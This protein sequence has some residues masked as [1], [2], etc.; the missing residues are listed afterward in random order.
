MANLMVW[1][2]ALGVI[3][4]AAFMEAQESDSPSPLY[5]EEVTASDPGRAEQ[6][7]ELQKYLAGWQKERPALRKRFTPD[8]ASPQAYEVSTRK[9]RRT[10]RNSLG[11]PPPGQPDAEFSQ[12]KVIG[13]DSAA[14]YYRARISALPGVHVI[15][16]Y[17]VPKARQGRVPLVIA[18][19]GGGGSPELAT[20]HGGA[21][22]HDMVRGAVA[23]GYA[24]WAP[25][26][27]FA[28]PGFPSD[29][30]QRIDA[31]AR[32]VGT[33]ITAIEIAKISRGLD[34]VS[35]RPEVDKNRI[36]MIGLSYGG[37][38]TLYTTA[39]EP[40]IKVAVS[41]CIFGNRGERLFED[42]P[43]AWSD[44]RFPHGAS[45]FPDSEIVALICPRPLEIQMGVKDDLIPIEPARREAPAAAAYYQ[46]L[47]LSDRF[48]FFEFDG[49]HEFYGKSAWEFLAKRL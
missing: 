17:I 5:E 23:R 40:R 9:L 11:Y 30:R 2:L 20:F 34:V 35:R 44:M 12:I 8:F 32:L 7:Q 33:T 26:H 42:E 48:R 21:N 10:L 41:S 6:A 13:Q 47:G 38:Y 16:L 19:H 28:A 37:F 39:L 43:N 45:L 25:Q 27:L 3:A 22:Y 31:Q 29:I 49:G 24:V 46:K 14:L 18:M 4:L 15:G 36:A 1:A